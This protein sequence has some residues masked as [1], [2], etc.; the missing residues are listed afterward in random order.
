[1]NKNT[2]ISGENSV[3]FS[4]TNKIVDCLGPSAPKIQA[5]GYVDPKPEKRTQKREKHEK[6]CGEFEEVLFI[7]A[8]MGVERNREKPSAPQL[9]GHVSQ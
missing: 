9:Q 4:K 5:Q 2:P 7:L 8:K 1:M 6:K 3:F